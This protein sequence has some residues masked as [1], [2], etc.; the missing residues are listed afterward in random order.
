MEDKDV[1]IGEEERAELQRQFRGFVELNDREGYLK[2]LSLQPDFSPASP[3]RLWRGN[4]AW[5]AARAEFAKAQR[6][7]QERAAARRGK[8]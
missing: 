6:Q 5:K 3:R 7:K 2:W 1:E 8:P 4:A